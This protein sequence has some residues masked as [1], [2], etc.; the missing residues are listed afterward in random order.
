MANG[1]YRKAAQNLLEGKVNLLTDTVKAQL[2]GWGYEVD[3][4][5]HQWLSDI[6]A[7]YRQVPAVTLIGKSCTNGVF[8]ADDVTFAGVHD[9]QLPLST[10]FAVVLYLDK[11]SGSAESTPL[12]AYL[13]TLDGIWPAVI[14]GTRTFSIGWANSLSRIFKV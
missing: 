12:L 6:A 14:I 9:T 4:A 3:F 5:Q 8:D 1:L 13:D 2:I 10:A 7:D 11:G